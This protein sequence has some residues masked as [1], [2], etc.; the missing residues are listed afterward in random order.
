MSLIADVSVNRQR[1]VGAV[2][3]KRLDKFDKS[4]T[5]YRYSVTEPTGF[6]GVEL[7]HKYSDGWSVLLE[8]ALRII[9]GT[10]NS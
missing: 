6:E 9:N 2:K 8:K 7:F 1:R 10:I 4:D 5:T 3:I